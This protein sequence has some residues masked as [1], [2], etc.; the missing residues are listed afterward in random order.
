MELCFQAVFNVWR[1][2]GRRT[3]DSRPPQTAASRG[4]LIDYEGVAKVSERNLHIPRFHIIFHPVCALS[5]RRFIRPPLTPPSRSLFFLFF[6]LLKRRISHSY[7]CKLSYQGILSLRRVNRMI[8][9]TAPCKFPL[10]LIY[11]T[12]EFFFP[13]MRVNRVSLV[14]PTLPQDLQHFSP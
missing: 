13:S 3:A 9:F 1:R 10:F 14:Y 2:L 7:P 12:R 6:S 4:I 11:F 5:Y 8:F